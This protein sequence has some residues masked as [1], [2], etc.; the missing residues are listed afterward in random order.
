MWSASNCH[1]HCNTSFISDKKSGIFLFLSKFHKYSKSTLSLTTFQR[2][3][4]QSYA[5]KYRSIEFLQLEGTSEGYLFKL[6]CY[7]IRLLTVWSSQVL[8]IIHINSL[9]KV[10]F[11][12]NMRQESLVFRVFSSFLAAL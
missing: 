4:I 5:Y 11:K 8:N 7:K 3:S 2:S 9:I 6:P 10:T 1:Y 12:L